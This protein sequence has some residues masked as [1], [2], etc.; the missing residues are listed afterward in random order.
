MGKERWTPTKRM[1]RGKTEKKKETTPSGN[2]LTLVRVE[3]GTLR[4]ACG[5]TLVACRDLAAAG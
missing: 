1:G 2:V 3:R 4:H 5:A